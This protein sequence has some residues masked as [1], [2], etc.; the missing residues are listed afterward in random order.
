MGLLVSGPRPLKQQIVATSSENYIC[1]LLYAD[2]R[3][4]VYAVLPSY[5]LDHVALVA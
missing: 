4:H 2:L 5:D 1:E 3:M